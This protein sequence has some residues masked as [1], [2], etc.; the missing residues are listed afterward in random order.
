MADAGGWDVDDEVLA[1]RAGRAWRLLDA[2]LNQVQAWRAANPTAP[3][4]SDRALKALAADVKAR[5]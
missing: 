3:G 4:I 1:R 2:R 5:R